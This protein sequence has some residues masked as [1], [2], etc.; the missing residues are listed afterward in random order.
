MIGD[1][2]SISSA[3]VWMSLR[4]FMNVLLILILVEGFSYAYHFS[5]KLFSDY[6]Y[7]A[8][9]ANAVNITIEEGSNAEQIATVLDEMGIVDGKYL[10]LARVYIGGYHK[11]IKA[12]TYS[13]GP[14]MSPD[15]ICRE[16]CGMQSEGTV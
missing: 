12:G 1:K 11:K 15:E 2:K 10:F 16:I 8:S 5:H 14:G 6:P 7:A 3:L 4:I 9:A 13:L